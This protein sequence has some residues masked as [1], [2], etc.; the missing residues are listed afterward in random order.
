MIDDFSFQLVSSSE[1]SV[2]EQEQTPHPNEH[3]ESVPLQGVESAAGAPP[4]D[5]R[6]E[7]SE[8]LNA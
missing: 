2:A 8:V 3:S 1:L 4:E 6:A 7:P 5:G